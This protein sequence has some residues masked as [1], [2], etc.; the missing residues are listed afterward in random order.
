MRR[1]ADPPS[2]ALRRSGKFA[3]LRLQLPEHATESCHVLA[4]RGG[5]ARR[6]KQ[7]EAEQCRYSAKDQRVPGV[8]T[9]PTA[10]S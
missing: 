4:L 10:R 2:R 7:H 3:V 9:V 8:V 1:V 5:G 6:D